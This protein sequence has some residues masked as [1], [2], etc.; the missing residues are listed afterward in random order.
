M[1]A[2][3]R[4]T[5]HV[6]SDVREPAAQSRPV[7][8]GRDGQPIRRVKVGND[9]YYV[10]PSIIP[11]GWVY[12]WKRHTI[13]G[14]EDPGYQAELARAGFTAVPAERHDGMF[15]PKGA[16]G[17]II[18]GGQILMERPEELEYEARMEEKHAADAQVRGSKEQF[19][20]VPRARGFE[21]PSESSNP[22]VRQSTFAR[23]SVE[24]VDAP[25]PKHDL[26]VD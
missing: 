20:L 4:S 8:V 14:Q 9:K 23:S 18:L 17:S 19:G 21:G 15:L 7:V 12:Q 10:D 26:A 3:T 6:R 11:D 24:V 25:R 13:L 16:K 2:R 5:S 1:V 22:R